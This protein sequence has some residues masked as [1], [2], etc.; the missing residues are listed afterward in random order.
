MASLVKKFID[1]SAGYCLA[2]VFPIHNF[3]EGREGGEKA[4]SSTRYINE[5]FSMFRLYRASYLIHSRHGRVPLPYLEAFSRFL[6]ETENRIAISL[7]V[8]FSSEVR[9]YTTI[10]QYQSSVRD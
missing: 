10:G 3:P 5:Y 8:F 1:Y 2:S 7:N 6:S 4:S 9:F